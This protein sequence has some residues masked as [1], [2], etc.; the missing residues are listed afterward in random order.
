MLT[1]VNT[2]LHTGCLEQRP[3]NSNIDLVVCTA[4]C[5][6]LRVLAKIRRG[7][8]LAAGATSISRA[9]FTAVEPV[10]SAAVALFAGFHHVTTSCSGFP[11]LCGRDVH[12]C[13]SQRPCKADESTTG[14]GSLERR[15]VRPGGAPAEAAGAAARPAQHP[16]EW[17]RPDAVDGGDPSWAARRG[18]ASAACRG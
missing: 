12:A 7:H 4:V 13:T 9:E 18:E 5:T 16:R 11:G 14:A 2:M 17:Q 8:P 3:S 15:T 10:Y 1:P 6:V